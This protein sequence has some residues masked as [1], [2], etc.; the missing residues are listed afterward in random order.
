MES[1]IGVRRRRKILRIVWD[2]LIQ[3]PES[4][5]PCSLNHFPLLPAAWSFW[6]H[7][8]CTFGPHSPRSLNPLAESQKTLRVVY[9]MSGCIILTLFSQILFKILILYTDFTLTIKILIFTFMHHE[10]MLHTCLNIKL[11]NPY[12]YNQICLWIFKKCKNGQI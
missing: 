6:P 1:K 5:A 8:P 11:F 12:F 9:S 2:S 4:S 10:I 3:C 7:A